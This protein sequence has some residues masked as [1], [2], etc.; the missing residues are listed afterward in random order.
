MSLTPAPASLQAA[1]IEKLEQH[2]SR[3][4]ASVAVCSI[5]WADCG[6][7]AALH[8]RGSRLIITRYVSGRPPLIVEVPASSPSTAAPTSD[9]T[10]VLDMA[11]YCQGRAPSGSTVLTLVNPDA[12]MHKTAALLAQVYI[13]PAHMLRT[14]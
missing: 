10:E 13:L 1:A 8:G 12:T 3:L 7:E 11:P 2:C 4:P 5:A 14:R 6:T 9:D